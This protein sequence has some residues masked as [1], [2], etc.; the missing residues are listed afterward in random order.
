M[1]PNIFLC[2]HKGLFTLEFISLFY[3]RPFI[4]LRQ[5]QHYYLFVFLP[6]LFSIFCLVRFANKKEQIAKH[7]RELFSWVT[8]FMRKR[9]R[10]K[11]ALKTNC[12]CLA[13]EMK[14]GVG[15]FWFR[16]SII[17]SRVATS[18]EKNLSTTW[19]SRD[20]K[21]GGGGGDDGDDD[22][23]DDDDG[24]DDSDTDDDGDCCCCCCCCC[25]C[26]YSMDCMWKAWSIRPVNT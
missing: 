25:C 22:D 13:G 19:T 23:D 24:G 10:K 5:T 26:W 7:F 4:M 18:R 11:T 8:K 9:I 2:S 16:R 12:M 15:F 3:W 21:S 14:E 1:A 6:T 17:Q 20:F